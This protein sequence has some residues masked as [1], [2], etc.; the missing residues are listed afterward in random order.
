MFS[1]IYVTKKTFNMCMWLLRLD[2]TVKTNK[3]R[4]TLFPCRMHFPCINGFLPE[5]TDLRNL[6]TKVLKKPIKKNL[7]YLKDTIYYL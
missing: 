1:F 3:I 2:N 6:F 5:K 4:L 7:I